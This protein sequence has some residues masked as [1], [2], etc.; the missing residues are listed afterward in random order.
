M[1]SLFHTSCS[2]IYSA[3]MGDLTLYTALDPAPLLLTILR[4]VCIFWGFVFNPNPNPNPLQF[5]EP[6]DHK[7]ATTSPFPYTMPNKAKT[8]AAILSRLWNQSRMRCTQQG[9][10]VLGKDRYH[11]VI[12]SFSVWLEKGLFFCLSLKKRHLQGK[13]V[14]L[15]F[16]IH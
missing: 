5:Q 11:L 8:S 10:P 2:S 9:Y 12:E 6:L 4:K 1:A 15:H 13:W 7:M 3:P 14:P 16:C